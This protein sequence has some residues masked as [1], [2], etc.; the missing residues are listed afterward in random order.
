MEKQPVTE[1]TLEDAITDG[2][3]DDGPRV[4]RIWKTEQRFGT[5]NLLSLDRPS[6]E[7]NFEKCMTDYSLSITA[8]QE[9]R[10]LG[11]GV[12]ELESGYIYW[13]GKESGRKEEGVGFYVKKE[14]KSSVMKFEALGSLLARLRVKARWHNITFSVH[15]PTEVSE[16][17]SKDDW[18]GLMEAAL[19][20]VP[21]HDVLIVLGDWNAKVGR[22]TRAFKPAIGAHSLHED[23]NGNGVRLATFALQYGLVIGEPF[24]PIRI[25]TKEPGFPQTAE[26]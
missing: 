4:K 7:Q 25:G 18:Y 20:K 19:E 11:V 10:W 21:R 26:R 6:A 9:I 8:L 16:E 2:T 15:A 5:W 3:T 22:E 14:L 24:F 12:K 1:T 17:Q 13:S 23:S